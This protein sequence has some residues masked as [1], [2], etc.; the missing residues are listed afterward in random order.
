[1]PLLCVCSVRGDGLPSGQGKLRQE[2]TWL[3]MATISYRAV[4]GYAYLCGMFL[5][6]TNHDESIFVSH[7]LLWPP[8]KCI[9]AK[10]P[11][12]SV[13]RI[14]RVALSD[15]RWCDRFVLYFVIW[16]VN[17]TFPPWLHLCLQVLY[18]RGKWKPQTIAFKGSLTNLASRKIWR[19]SFFTSHV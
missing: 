11:I 19:T 6:H 12:L 14:P 4:M 10:E 18:V 13:I 1:M 5:S 17:V 3:R 7:S 15:L 9:S 2:N 8:V 16:L